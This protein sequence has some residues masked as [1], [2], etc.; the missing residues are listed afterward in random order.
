MVDFV[1][2][3]IKGLDEVQRALRSMPGEL[4]PEVKKAVTR[5]TLAVH[6]EAI[7][8][9]QRGPASGRVYVRR[10]I[11]HRASAPGQAPATDTGRLV[12]SIVPVIDSD[13]FGGRVQ[14][15]VLYAKFLEFGTLKMAARPFMLPSLEAKRDAIV[16]L[17]ADAARRAVARAARR[18][19][20]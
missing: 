6:A 9:V 2:I 8:R 4:A 19:K 18:T 5:G 20:K 13:G 16:K 7:K 14:A 12:A 11:A 1:S 17:L 15:R 3:E 10:G